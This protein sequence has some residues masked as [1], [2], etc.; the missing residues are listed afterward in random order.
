MG[1]RD[2]DESRRAKIDALLA[3]REE[4]E[5]RIE[6]LEE[7]V[8]TLEARLEALSEELPESSEAKSK[9]KPKESKSESK[10]E[11]K[12]GSKAKAKAKPKKEL[13]T[14]ELFARRWR[15]IFVIGGVFILWCFAMMYREMIAEP[16]E[17]PQAV[18]A[19][20]PAP[21]PTSP[22]RTVEWDGSGEVSLEELLEEL[23]PAQET[24]PPTVRPIFTGHVSLATSGASV[25]E[26][27]PCEVRMTP[28]DR[29]LSLLP[30]ESMEVRCGGETLYQIGTPPPCTVRGQGEIFG[31]L[32]TFAC[33]DRGIRE[34]RPEMELSSVDRH[35]RV[36]SE[37]QNWMVTIVLDRAAARVAL[38]RRLDAGAG[39]PLATPESF[40]LRVQEHQGEG[41]PSNNTM[42]TLTVSEAD[43]PNANCAFT[44]R[45]GRRA[46][47]QSEGRCVFDSQL[48]LI[49]I[50][51]GLTE[52][53]R[54]GLT[55]DLREERVT[56][57][58]A[59]GERSWA[60]QTLIEDDAP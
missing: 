38:S 7:R 43:S 41:A 46:L 58:S 2:H 37:T 53:R 5:E 39:L 20:S 51:A 52:E 56:I 23:S 21:A 3:Q 57:E 42:L 11:S 29:L 13:D 30:P 32:F 31:G 12:S 47:G 35:L 50:E 59:E 16:E 54:L 19:S 24:E 60:A 6:A 34:E 1:F 17:T 33:E 25:A 4:H 10:A 8:E 26:G 36:W 45:E 9:A 15:A 40:R 55:M 28:P 27:A 18:Q 14:V 22:L 48:A 49:G 44:V